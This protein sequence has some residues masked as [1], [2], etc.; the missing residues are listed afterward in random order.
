[1][2]KNTFACFLL[3]FILSLCC[4]KPLAQ[5]NVTDLEVKLQE[6][7]VGIL[8][9]AADRPGLDY[10]IE[11]I[12]SGILTL[13]NTRAAF[14]DPAQ[15]E[16]TEIY[17]GL[18][19]T[20]LVIA[21]YENF[22]ERAPEQAGLLYWVDELNNGRVNAD[23]MI[24]AVIN[25]VQDPNASGEDSA[26]DLAV[27]KNKIAAALYFSELAS[28]FAVDAA[29]KAAARAAV[30]DVTDDPDS[31]VAAM[32]MADAYFQSF[33]TNN[34]AAISLEIESPNPRIGYPLEVSVTIDAIEATESV[35]VAFFAI[36]KDRPNARQISLGANII[37]LVDVGSDS[38]E[39]ILDIT[40]SLEI[41]GSYYIGAV[42]DAANIVGESNEGDNE[43]STVTTLSPVQSPNLFI[44]HMDP[45]RTALV[46]DRRAFNYQEQVQM[47][48]VNSDAGGTVT[49]GVKGAEE[50]IAVEAFAFLRLTR[51]DD[52]GGEPPIVVFA[53][54]PTPSE[55]DTSSSHDVPLY[56]WNSIAERYMNAYGVDPGQGATGIEEW[57]PIGQIGQ[58]LVEGADGREDVPVSEF[59]RKSAHLDFYFPGSLAVEIETALRH[60]DV[61]FG[62]IEPPPDLSAADIQALRDFLFGVE[63]EVLS[64]ALCV[65]IRPSDP[66]VL[67]DRTD[68]NEIC[69]PL[70]LVLPVLPPNPPVPVSPPEP[71]IYLDPSNPVFIEQLFK[72][73]WGGKSFGFGITFSASA[74]A[75]NRGVIVSAQGALPVKVFG[76]G[77]EFMKIA[78]R[79]QVVP[80]SD[81]DNPPPGQTPGFTLELSHV[82]LVL[83]S[84]TVPSGTV[85]PLEL[86]FSKEYPPK[87]LNEGIK[88]PIG[89]I[90]V[91]LKAQVAGNI[92]VEYEITF[93]AEAGSGL[94]TG[95]AP[96]ANIEASA[97][98]A[99]KVGIADIGVEGV[100]TLVEEKFKIESSA[101]ISV[102]DDRHFDG[103]SEVVIEQTLKV[104]N[105]IT[106]PKGAINAFVKVDIPV[107]R[108]CSW[109]FFTGICPGIA[110]LKY[111]YNL[112]NWDGYEK[113]DTLIDEQV[114]IDIVTLPNG[115]V[116][117][118]K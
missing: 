7:Y 14:T 4:L 16:Y 81:R 89:P 66:D 110:E 40:T 24:N 77:F 98:A 34:L 96:F 1:M 50:P 55:A 53:I 72:T 107:F 109:G 17:G 57:L 74:S 26:K 33:Q 115:T 3:L 21:V 8:G 78:G 35:S 11:Q 20:Q 18:D 101:T 88:I 63:P 80:V 10:W 93:G 19:N 84:I 108:K 64:S 86:S 48:V 117:Y 56:L 87:E 75:D 71:P 46:M 37:E 5:Q 118:Y 23:Q 91:T 15:A 59:D 52:T 30:A 73:A 70:A 61:P 2:K 100:I 79:A 39:L 22:L 102:E 92:G 62:P 82:G 9:R 60:L 104:I 51:S 103:T 27:L 54:D 47:G 45:D 29:F 41:A 112:E 36:D 105:E 32:A 67:E 44:E 6:L 114:L 13:E 42:V 94:A 68:D 90:Y 38:Y 99:V 76:L 83:S 25:A 116:N 65:K 69:S 106:G 28:D 111:P 43:T 97:E 113:R 49:W 85:G 12:T 31:L 95:L 58:L